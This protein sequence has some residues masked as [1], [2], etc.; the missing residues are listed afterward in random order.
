MHT[1]VYVCS[2]S[3]I[4]SVISN[5]YFIHGGLCI[6]RERNCLVGRP[7][8]WST[9]ARSSADTAGVGRSRACAPSASAELG[10]R[11][12]CRQ[13]IRLSRTLARDPPAV[14]TGSLPRVGWTSQLAGQF[15]HRLVPP[16]D[17]TSFDRGLRHRVRG[18]GVRG[19]EHL[20]QGNYG[21]PLGDLRARRCDAVA[22]W[23]CRRTLGRASSMPDAETR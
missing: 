22:R 23:R 14:S 19:L 1:D 11:L 15:A 3:S 16:R 9:H 2:I 8:G 10:P 5:K 6:Y 13:S 18:C 21:T 4:T 12:K 20:L 17:V 7:A